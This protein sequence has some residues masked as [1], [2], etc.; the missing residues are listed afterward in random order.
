MTGLLPCPFCNRQLE[1]DTAIEATRHPKIPYG[2]YCPLNGFLFASDRT[3]IIKAWNTRVAQP[4]ALTG[5]LHP[6]NEPKSCQYEGKCVG[7]ACNHYGKTERCPIMTVL[8]QV[9]G[10]LYPKVDR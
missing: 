2:E 9:D 1:H 6:G 4:E 10:I 5:C 3:D 8:A 7:Y